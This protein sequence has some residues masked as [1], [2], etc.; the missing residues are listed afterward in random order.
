MLRI[1]TLLVVLAGTAHADPQVDDLR[2][3]R[4]LA[5]SA[6]PART[7]LHYAEDDARRVGQ[8]CS[9]SSAAT[10]PTTVDV[11]RRT[12]RPTS[13]A[14][15]LAKLARARRERITRPAARRACSSI[16]AATRARRRSI[17]ATAE[18]P[19]AELRTAAVR[20]SGD[21]HGRRARRL[22]E[23]RV[24]A[25]Q[26][27]RARRRLLVSARGSTSMRSG[28]AV[29]ASSSGSELS[30]ESE[31]LQSVVLHASLARR[32]ARRRRREPRRPGLARRGLSLRLSPDAARDRGDRRR[33]P[34][35]HAR[36]RSQGPRRGA[37]VV[38][39]RGDR[40]RSSCR[41]SSRARRSSRTSARTPSSP[42]RTRR[43][44]RRC[45]SR[46][47]RAS[48]TCSSGTARRCRAARSARRHASSSITARARRLSSR[49]RK[50][51]GCR[52]SRTQRS[53]RARR[54]AGRERH[55]A[56]TDSLKGFGYNEDG[57]APSAGFEVRGLRQ[58]ARRRLGRRHRRAGDDAERGRTTRHE[59]PDLTQQLDWTTYR[60]RDGARARRAAESASSHF[61]VTREM[62]AGL[63]IGHTAPARTPIDM[64][65]D[66][67]H[68][69]PAFGA[70]AGLHLEHRRSS[71]A[72]A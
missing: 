4:R 71:P 68:V 37:A 65:Y 64:T 33:R 35:R 39:A 16:T 21:A 57:L 70:G 19:L 25:R 34:A 22:S 13:C 2:A 27:R 44:A 47:R 10:R 43:R 53:H 26:G 18:L 56:Y 48:T 40:R 32:A 52:D 69:G 28:V 14:T 60:R 20:D 63:G 5:T 17:S 30:Q 15:R 54:L 59:R 45:A 23:R 36:G 24:L 29:L 9:P 6:V 62:A 51:G 11:R 67:Y 42:R 72:S 38:S 55:D 1:L 66:D 58:V 41:R 61:S 3:R 12:R 46:S 7:A 8:R 31:Q 49:R 50:G